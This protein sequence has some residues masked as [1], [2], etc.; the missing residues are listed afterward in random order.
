MIFQTC[1]LV[2]GDKISFK[3]IKEESISGVV[4]IGG[5]VN[6]RRKFSIR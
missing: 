5:A 1:N 2:D 6:I 3:E 4:K